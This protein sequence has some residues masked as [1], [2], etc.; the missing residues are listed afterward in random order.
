MRRCIPSSFSPPTSVSAGQPAAVKVRVLDSR[1]PA[2]VTAT[3]HWRIAGADAWTSAPMTRRVKAIFTGTMPAAGLVEYYLTV[4]EGERTA[5][6]PVTGN[7]TFV[8]TGAAPAA[9]RR[10]R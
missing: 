9:S 2:A 6:F 10:P 7:L 1:D 5:R 3:L 4:A 8:T